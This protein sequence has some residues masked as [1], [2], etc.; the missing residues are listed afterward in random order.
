M[1]EVVVVKAADCRKATDNLQELE[2]DLYRLKSGIYDICSFDGMDE[3]IPKD[4]KVL[5]NKYK[6]D[7]DRL[8]DDIKSIHREVLNKVCIAK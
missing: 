7:L 4:E 3:C 8:S 6:K 2:H 5:L 1:G